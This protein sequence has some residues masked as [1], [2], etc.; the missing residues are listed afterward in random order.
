M[1]KITFTNT[2]TNVSSGKIVDFGDSSIKKYPASPDSFSLKPF[3]IF[4]EG[5][6]DTIDPDTLHSDLEDKVDDEGDEDKDD[7][8]YEDTNETE[9]NEDEDDEVNTDDS[10]T[11]DDETTEESEESEM[12][13]EESETEPEEDEEYDLK[14]FGKHGG[15]D[16][17]NNQYN[18]KDVEILN[19]LI[20]SENDAINDYFD[21][22][23]N[24]TDANLSRLYGDIGKEERFHLEQLMYAKSLIT[25]EKYE[26]RDPEV[27]K[28][29]EELVGSGMDEDTAICTVIDKMSI[30]SDK[31]LSDEEFE[32][33]KDDV[34][35][36]EAYLMQS[37][38][39]AEMVVT[40]THMELLQEY[41]TRMQFYVE[42]VLN[43]NT[44]PK[45]D[46]TGTSPVKWIIQQFFKFIKFLKKLGTLLREHLARRRTKNNRMKAFIEK[47]GLS[48]IFKEGYSFY[49]Y[50]DK[51]GVFTTS[52]FIQIADL[53]YRTTALI[54]KNCNLAFNTPS[55][56]QSNALTQGLTP[57]CAN[58]N[59]VE[60]NIRFIK[61][62]L[63][64]KTKL[65]INESNEDYIKN[66]LFGYTPN[67][68]SH[69][70]YAM[71]ENGNQTATTSNLSKNF[72]NITTITLDHITTIAT[73][74]ED[75]VKEL[76]ALDGDQS[77]VF[78]S[79]HPTWKKS[80][81][82][83]GDV[84]SAFSKIIN[85]LNSDINTMVKIDDYVYSLTQAH[86]QAD[87][88]HTKYEGEVRKVGDGKQVDPNAPKKTS[89]VQRIK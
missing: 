65:L 29:Y 46:K 4:T 54:G 80:V 42:D 39:F 19:K 35:T 75:M 24:T 77:S 2:L 47:Y 86:D 67:K 20:A 73:M 32:E 52:A 88:T 64:T 10:D 84:M 61:G 48:A 72:Y 8:E 36:T 74:C 21:A 38:M 43:V 57:L 41:S 6:T 83:M 89:F 11:D 30:S 62:I 79:N 22:T 50:D 68:T 7:D 53:L 71:D 1:D 18:E 37:E 59:S 9:E 66:Y 15:P 58:S 14:D 23:T 34:A 3:S 28:E 31:V 25:G 82:Y 69:T 12:D 27:K 70:T 17:P 51:K 81:A 60:F 56:L 63:L 16:V 26:P 45:V 78:R 85:A 13:P 49:T 87:Q 55:P 33:L 5:T 40:E 44:L 76:A